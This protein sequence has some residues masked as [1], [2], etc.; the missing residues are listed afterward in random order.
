MI[1]HKVSDRWGQLQ[2]NIKDRTLPAIDALIAA[3]ANTHELTLVTR[4]VK[5]F[6]HTPVT[7][8]NPWEAT[9]Y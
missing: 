8:I 1:N 4:N 5:D 9:A 2:S 6:I 3:T 7:V